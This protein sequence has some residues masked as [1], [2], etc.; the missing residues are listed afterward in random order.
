[1][2]ALT[3]NTFPE[4]ENT[5]TKLD[6][7]SGPHTLAWVTDSYLVFESA[8]TGSLT[9]N[10]IGDGVSTVPCVGYGDV[11]V[12]LGFDITLTA[13]D[14][15]VV[16]LSAISAF[17]GGMKNNVTLTVTGSTAPSLA[18]VYWY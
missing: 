15:V 1:M 3:R 11:D 4:Q 18:Y 5:A 17:L 14:T 16:P 12:S 8:E 6:L 2:A 10:A 13:G 9:I 7:N